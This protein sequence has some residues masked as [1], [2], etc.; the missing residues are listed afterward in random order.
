MLGGCNIKVILRHFDEEVGG[1]RALRY[2]P[3]HKLLTFLKA[4]FFHTFLWRYRSSDT[5]YG[6]VQTLPGASAWLLNAAEN[7][8][9]WTDNHIL[10]AP[11]RNISTQF[12]ILTV[13]FKE[14]TNGCY[15]NFDAYFLMR[16]LWYTL[17]TS[18]YVTRFTVSDIY[19]TIEKF[20][21]CYFFY[22]WLNNMNLISLNCTTTLRF[23]YIKNV[24]Y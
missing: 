1:V 13:Y 12:T 10:F 4:L 16:T 5:S 20:N 11:M 2:L 23:F 8:C 24:K 15:M 17:K 9:G 6:G 21:L 18:F 3:M 7:P 22:F 19:S 14:G